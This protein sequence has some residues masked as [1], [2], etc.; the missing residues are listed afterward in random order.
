MVCVYT[1]LYVHMSISRKSTV[2]LYYSIPIHHQ[3]PSH[4]TTQLAKD[5]RTQY[6]HHII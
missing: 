1:G 2:P 4:H 5:E 3:H 6:R